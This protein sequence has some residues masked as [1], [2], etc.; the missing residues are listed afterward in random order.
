MCAI[1][2]TALHLFPYLGVTLLAGYVI[3]PTTQIIPGMLS[4]EERDRTRQCED[5]NCNYRD[6]TRF[7]EW[8]N[9]FCFVLFYAITR[10]IV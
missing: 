4:A 5:A 6:S 2:A 1:I 9:L 10:D 3:N 8:L 7:A